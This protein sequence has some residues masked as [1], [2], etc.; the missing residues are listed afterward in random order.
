M[1][2]P[3]D[4][5]VKQ[6]NKPTKLEPKA[7]KLDARPG[8]VSL[9]TIDRLRR[10]EDLDDLDESFDDDDDGFGLEPLPVGPPAA[11]AKPNPVELPAPINPEGGRKQSVE[12]HRNLFCAHYD[13]CLDEA[14]KRGWNSFT[15]LRCA[16]YH[17]GKDEAGG[18][19]R[20][21]TQRRMS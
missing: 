21:A 16:F 7:P 8:K 15:C 1:K 14:V 11:D 2:P 13:E 10:D 17:T 20:F 18:V 9:P 3:E 6:G 19:E 4:K 12:M 5:Q